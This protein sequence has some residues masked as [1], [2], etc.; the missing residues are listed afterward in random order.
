MPYWL[1]KTPEMIAM[2]RYF[3]GPTAKLIKNYK[4]AIA[5]VEAAAQTASGLPT[6]SDALNDPKNW[7]GQPNKA[8]A[9]FDTDWLNPNN[10]S[11]GGDYWPQVPTLS[12]IPWF[13]SGILAGANKG[14]GWTELVKTPVDPNK[15]FESELEYGMTE[16]ELADPLPLATSWVCTSPPGTGTVEVDAV[17]GPSV[18]ELIIATPWPKTMQSRLWATVKPIIDQQWVHLHG[19]PGPSELDLEREASESS[20]ISS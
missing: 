16:A 6:S 13:Q 8:F 3:S 7:P 18:V 15:L 2:D 19:G 11:S 4:A 17:R 12:I 9:H 10:P 5:R 20:E 14:L 1:N